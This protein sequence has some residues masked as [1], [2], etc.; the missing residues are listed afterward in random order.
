MLEVGSRGRRRADDGRV[1]RPAGG[2]EQ[3][4]ERE[5]GDDLE[6]PRG[7]VVMGDPV[8]EEVRQRAEEDRPAACPAGRSDG[9][10]CRDVKGDDQLS[11]W[12]TWVGSIR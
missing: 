5:P 8:A 4:E 12:K 10:T 6:A 11:M 2:R 1:E 3:A 7:D 9:G